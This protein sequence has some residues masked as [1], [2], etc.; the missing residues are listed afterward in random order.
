MTILK[1]VYPFIKS[2][3]MRFFLCCLLS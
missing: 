1:I 3:E 2:V